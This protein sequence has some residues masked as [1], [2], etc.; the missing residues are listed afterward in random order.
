ML[1]K[2]KNVKDTVEKILIEKPAFRDSDNLLIAYIWYGEAVKNN[3]DLSAKDLLGNYARGELTNAEAI[4]RA[5][6]KIQEETPALRGTNYKGRKAE[7]IVVQEGI[8]QI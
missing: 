5:R 3:P 6:Q 7:E 2:I 1:S 8:N 4:R